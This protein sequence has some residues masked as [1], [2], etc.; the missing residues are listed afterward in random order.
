MA[1]AATPLL[2]AGRPKA[3]YTNTRSPR[4]SE[5]AR[6]SDRP[7]RIGPAAGRPVER[8]LARLS[9]VGRSPNTV[10]AYAHDLKLFWTFLEARGLGWDAVALE[11]LGEFIG[12]L[13]HPAENVIV[14]S[15]GGVA[16]LAPERES[17]LGRRA[18]FLRVP[19]A[20]RRQ[21]G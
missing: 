21:G 20:R 1:A 11:Q 17:R 3:A 19:R 2:S 13:R 6:A 7:S 16:A 4:T 18:W 12:W 15:G 9:N 10:R 14:L 8:Y 5:W